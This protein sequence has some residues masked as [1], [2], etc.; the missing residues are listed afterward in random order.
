ML[1]YIYNKLQEQVKIYDGDGWSMFWNLS[2]W[3]TT[4]LNKHIEI[5]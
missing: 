4:N 2:F 5:H 3:S 1:R